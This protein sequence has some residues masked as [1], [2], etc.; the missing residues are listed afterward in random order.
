M[1]PMIAPRDSR[2]LPHRH[3]ILLCAGGS[4]R[5]GRPKALVRLGNAPLA[6]IMARRCAAASAGVCIV[7]LGAARVRIAAALQGL[8]VR[9]V[10]NR[11]WQSGQGSSLARGIRA[12]PRSATHA[13]VLA[14]DQWRI[15]ER[16]IRRLLRSAKERPIAARYSGRMGIPVVFPRCWFK[17][18]SG[19]SGERGAQALLDPSRVHARDL[20]EAAWDIDV[21][22]DMA[23][24]RRR[25]WRAR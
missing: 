4:R 20:P 24:A 2:L 9:M 19:L 23:P 13:L 12:L 25:G 6:R 21:G 15:D 1:Y 10:V 8:P 14:V 11:G 18:L 3:V 22:S 16:S 17:R 7:V 5:L